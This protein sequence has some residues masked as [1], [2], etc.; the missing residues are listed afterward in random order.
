MSESFPTSYITKKI[1]EVYKP[2]LLQ[3]W[4]AEA[5]YHQR[6]MYKLVKEFDFIGY[7]DEEL[8]MKIATDV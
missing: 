3:K 1:D 4:K 7:Y 8:W 5:T 2:V 6:L